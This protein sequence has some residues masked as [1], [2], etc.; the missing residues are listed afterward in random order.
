VVLSVV[1]ATLRRVPDQVETPRAT[2]SPP[3]EVTV[4]DRGRSVFIGQRCQRC[5]SLHGEGNKRSP[6]DGVGGRLSENDIRRWITAPQAMK[7]GIAKRAYKLSK[8]DLDALV[9]YLMK[10]EL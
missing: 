10:E 4:I 6:L 5:H 7:P 9:E 2:P 8:E 3:P 1:F